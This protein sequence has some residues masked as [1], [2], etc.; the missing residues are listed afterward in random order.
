MRLLEGSQLNVAFMCRYSV[1]KS[2]VRY[3]K[4]NSLTEPESTKYCMKSCRCETCFEVVVE[5]T[6]T[7]KVWICAC[8]ESDMC[9]VTDLQTL[10]L[11]STRYSQ[12]L[13]YLGL[14]VDY[15]CLLRSFIKFVVNDE[16]AVCEKEGSRTNVAV[17]PSRGL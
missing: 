10:N 3:N 4:V 1:Q 2:T 12:N 11:H 14:L 8:S 7:I 16:I 15:E 13:F 9:S 5:T 6:P 17:V